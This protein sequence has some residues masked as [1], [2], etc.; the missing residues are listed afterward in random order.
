MLCSKRSVT[1]LGKA[2]SMSRKSAE[3]TLPCLHACRTVLSRGWRGRVHVDTWGWGVTVARHRMLVGG[4]KKR[5]ERNKKYLLCTLAQY[6]EAGGGWLTCSHRHCRV[7]VRRGGHDWRWWVLVVSRQWTMHGDVMS[8]CHR[9]WW[10]SLTVVPMSLCRG[11]GHSCDG[12][13][14]KNTWKSIWIHLKVPKRLGNSQTHLV[15]G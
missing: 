3:T 7:I 6:T 11:C 8:C 14:L 1:V 4:V 15:K 13:H 9:K 5:N 12:C 2:P 10:P